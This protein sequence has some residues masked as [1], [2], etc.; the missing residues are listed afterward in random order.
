MCLDANKDIYKKSIGKTLTS[1]EGLGM[2]EIVGDF[3]GQKIGATFFREKNP[4][5]GYGLQ[6]TSLSLVLV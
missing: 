6:V 2:S 5:T 4:Y 1:I 3:T